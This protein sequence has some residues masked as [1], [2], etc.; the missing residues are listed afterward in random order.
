MITVLS[1]KRLLIFAAPTFLE[2]F[3]MTKAPTPKPDL[4][5]YEEE[6]VPFDD[7]MQKL[8]KAKTMPEKPE[9]Q[10]KEKPNE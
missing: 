7:V 8:M 9:P 10:K 2:D 1:P 4:T 3:P 6:A 5:E